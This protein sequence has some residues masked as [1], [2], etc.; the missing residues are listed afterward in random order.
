MELYASCVRVA[1]LQ[2]YVKRQQAA[3]WGHGH[4]HR[5]QDQDVGR[6]RG[7]Q[8]SSRGNADGDSPAVGM[9]R[10]TMAACRVTGELCCS[11]EADQAFV[12]VW[13]LDRGQPGSDSA[14]SSDYA[15]VMRWTKG[16]TTSAGNL[17]EPLNASSPVPFLQRCNPWG[18]PTSI[19][20]NE[21]I[22]YD[23]MRYKE[24]ALGPFSGLDYWAVR[25]H[26][27]GNTTVL[28]RC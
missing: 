17:H 21:T 24:V 6:D 3:W 20:A 9:A 27:P 15:E 26:M 16:G 1:R 28:Y 4:G 11:L 14:L 7:Q 23:E 5:G 10:V 19:C 25:E 18:G 22:A 12:P 8:A 13:Y 2:T